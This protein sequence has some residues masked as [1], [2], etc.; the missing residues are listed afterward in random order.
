MVS[1]IK[2]GI[3]N[4]GEF[5]N[6]WAG[7]K[8]EITCDDCGKSQFKFPCY[9]KGR[10]NHFCNRKCKG[11]YTS[12][13]LKGK[14]NYHWKGGRV[15]VLGGYIRLYRPEHPFKD[16]SNYVLEHRLVMEK[17]IGRFLTRGEVVHHINENTSDNRPENL[18][19][20]KNC[21]EHTKH[22]AKLTKMIEEYG[23]I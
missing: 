22:H 4:L 8:K 12:K 1:E 23:R 19:L 21:A 7:G 16:S 18:M 9:I 11:R 14:N 15:K 10:T 3:H 20:F 13:I 17:K 2:K 5:H 6:R